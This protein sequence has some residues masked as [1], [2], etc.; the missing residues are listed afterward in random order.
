LIVGRWGR[1]DWWGERDLRLRHRRGLHQLRKVHCSL[2]LLRDVLHKLG[3]VDCLLGLRL[4][5][6][7]S[8]LGYI[9]RE[10]SII[11]R[12]LRSLLLRR[13]LHQRREI[14]GGVRGA[15]LR[16]AGLTLLRRLRGRSR[17][18]SSGGAV[19]SGL[20]LRTG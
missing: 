2:S 12:L 15:I 16:L 6:R 5:K 20:P 8:L 7:L 3:V 19:G 17:G 9:L 4:V 11:D 1:H 14:R 18:R 10:L 13:L